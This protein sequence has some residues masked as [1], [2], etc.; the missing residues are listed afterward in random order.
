[1]SA[2]VSTLLQD[3]NIKDGNF[4]DRLDNRTLYQANDYKLQ[5]TFLDGNDRA[6]GTDLAFSFVVQSTSGEVFD[7]A[8]AW[9]TATSGEGT[10]SVPA[11]SLNFTG[12]DYIGLIRFNGSVVA[13]FPLVVKAYGTPAPEA[14]TMIDW[15]IYTGYSST[16]THGPVRPGTGITNVVNADGSNTHS[17]TYGS[18]ASTAAEGNDARLSDART[19]T[20]HASTHATGGSDPVTAADV[21]VAGTAIAAALALKADDN[22]VVKLAPTPSTVQTVNGGSGFTQLNITGESGYLAVGRTTSGGEAVHVVR[23][24]TTSGSWQVGILTTAKESEHSAY[25]IYRNE[26]GNLFVGFWISQVDKL[27]RAVY[28]LVAP[29]I[30]S[31]ATTGLVVQNSAGT[32]KLKVGA[33]T[34]ADVQVTGTLS[35][36]GALTAETAI[37][38][39]VSVNAQTGLTYTLVLGDAGLIVTMT[40]AS[41]NTLTIPTNASVAYATGTVINVIMGGAGTT[42]ITGDTGVTVNGISAGSGDISAQYQGVALIKTGTDTW[43]AS[44]AIGTV[45]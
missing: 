16:A 7:I 19:P 40:N 32:E 9:T 5:L 34:G 22:A 36:T 25:E 35:T 11:A 27:C 18:T 41:A 4:V 24:E 10:I 28:G 1:M 23:D 26:T 39:A 3:I 30:K 8:G 12:T 45:A 37:G 2:T 38:K 33:S 31:A 14:G 44:G 17:V 21:D 42:T 29:I 20:A 43:I 6:D 13:E 15:S